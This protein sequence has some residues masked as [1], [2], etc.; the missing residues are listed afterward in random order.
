[1]GQFSNLNYG[2]VRLAWCRTALISLIRRWGIYV[3]VGLLVLGGAGSSAVAA[4]TAFAAWS[5][6]PLFQSALQPIGQA[7][8]MT[9]GYALVG[10]MVVWGLSPVLWPRAWAEAERA[11]PI[12]ER[13]QRISDL[14]VVLL[15]L[16]P[17]FAVYFAGAAI[18]LVKAPAWFQPVQSWALGM[19][20]T[21][22]ALSVAFGVVVI[23]HRRGL[24]VSSTPA[25]TGRK[26]RCGTRR[27]TNYQQTLSRAL[28]LVVIPLWRGPAQ[29][30]GRFFLL[31]LL[32][33]LTCVASLMAWP[34]HAAWSLA[35]FAALAQVLTT[36]LNVL[37]ST[38]LGPLHDACAALP[39]TELWLQSARHGVVMA[40][41]IISQTL[42]LMALICSPVAIKPAVW[43]TY[44]V[45]L[46][47]GNMALVA[48]SNAQ[49]D[50]QRSADAAARVSWWLLVLVLSLALASEVI[51]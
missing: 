9:I 1:M 27:A 33:L 28:A 13:E 49:S 26:G 4:I 45:T 48:A 25:R 10:G 40:P 38:E 32:A 6:L 50:M 37:V 44:L 18:W 16:T 8:L 39:I 46:P 12:A 17:L 35:A 20:L 3:M 51:V 30:S 31:S 7:F 2:Q 34:L 36:R 19:L 14:I 15:G 42:L 5:V 22:M 11:L 43:V 21:S 23:G 47:L 24:A 41:L 29:P